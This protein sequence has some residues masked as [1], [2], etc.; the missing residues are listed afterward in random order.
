MSLDEFKQNFH[1]KVDR[2]LETVSSL[3]GGILSI[4]LWLLLA[5]FIYGKGIAWYELK[6]VDTML[7]QIEHAI[8]YDEKFTADDGFFFAA[9]LIE[10]SEN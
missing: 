9:A 4:S 1:M 8:N 6:D 3:A 2:E 7:N 10:Y 5:I